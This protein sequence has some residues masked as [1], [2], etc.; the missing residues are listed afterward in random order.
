VVYGVTWN[1]NQWPSSAMFCPTGNG[2]T[3]NGFQGGV[4]A[5]VMAACTSRVRLDM[6]GDWWLAADF[7]FLASATSPHATCLV[8]HAD[9][10]GVFAMGSPREQGGVLANGSSSGFNVRA[11]ENHVSACVSG[12]QGT[13][14]YSYNTGGVTYGG[15]S[16]GTFA[17]GPPHNHAGGSTV[18]GRECTARR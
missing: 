2:V 12:Q 3:T 11:V 7:A 10:A 4:A 16:D 5:G 8:A 6:S 15:A 14:M 18:W 9:P 13:W 1:P 17:Q